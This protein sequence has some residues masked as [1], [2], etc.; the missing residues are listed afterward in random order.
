MGDL[1]ASSDTPPST[2]PHT[3]TFVR[4]EVGLC[5]PR[6]K[7]WKERERR[8]RDSKNPERSSCSPAS[9]CPRQVL[10]PRAAQE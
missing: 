10:W 3:H 2:D 1:D 4:Q 7:P 8:G 6:V 9:P 5:V